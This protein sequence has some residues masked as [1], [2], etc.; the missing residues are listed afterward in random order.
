MSS[1]ELQDLSLI[2]PVHRGDEAFLA[3]LEALALS[4]KRPLDTI[5]VQDGPEAQTGSMLEA[6]L[7]SWSGL[8]VVDLPQ[9][10]GPSAARNA[11]ALQARGNI[12]VFLDSDVALRPDSMERI[13]RTFAGDPGMTALFGSYDDSPRARNLLSQYKNLLNHHVHQRSKSEASTFWAGLGAIRRSVFQEVGGFNEQLRG[14]EDVDLGYRLRRAGHRIYLDKGLLCTHLKTWT[15]WNLL[16]ADFLHRA[17]PWTALILREGKIP[18]DLNTRMG[19]RVSVIAAYVGLG[20]TVYSFS[21]PQVL[22]LLPLALGVMGCANI[23]LVQLFY[24]KHGLRFA[25]GA[26]GWH[27]F[28]Y[29]YAGLAFG[30]GWVRHQLIQCGRIG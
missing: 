17:L 24:R 18:N 19:D 16:R 10:A 3:C 29:L 26:M 22:S 23:G 28:Q 9:N 7:G 25:M 20:A 27:G 12:L 13:H 5:V 15:A 11:G 21:Q 14:M 6:R 4:Q 8:V 1:T 30:L 2:I